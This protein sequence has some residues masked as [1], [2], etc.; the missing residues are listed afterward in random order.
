MET[1]I[2]DIIRRLDKLE[3]DS[4][5]MDILLKDLDKILVRG[6]GKPSMQEDVRTLVTFYKNTQF[7]M[8]TLAVAFIAQFIAVGTGMT[9]I[10][11]RAI[12]LL[13]EMII[14]NSQYVK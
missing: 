5:D 1:I 11:I 7:W 6:N 10:F 2:N 3:G 12:P 9:V 13:N 14:K 4:K 8:T